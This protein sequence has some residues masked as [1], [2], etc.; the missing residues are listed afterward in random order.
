MPELARQRTATALSMHLTSM[1]QYLTLM[2]TTAERWD[3]HHTISTTHPTTASIYG[4]NTTALYIY[5]V[6][7]YLRM[8]VK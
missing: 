1:L 6:R 7:P 3:Q 2:R 4:K 8:V 5:V